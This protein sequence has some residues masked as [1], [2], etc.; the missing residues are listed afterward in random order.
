VFRILIDGDLIL[1]A[2]MNRTEF[3]ADVSKLLEIVDPSIQLYLTNVGL[4]KIY[5]YAACL[6]NRQMAD[7]VVDWLIGRED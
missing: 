5:A 2:V 7:T 3:T 6:K 1:E 4:H